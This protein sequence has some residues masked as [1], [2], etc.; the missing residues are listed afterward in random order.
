MSEAHFAVLNEGTHQVLIGNAILE[1]E[2]EIL[3]KHMMDE[4][5]DAHG[6]L[7]EL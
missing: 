7:L 5:M 6:L 4:F 3:D 1:E 2:N